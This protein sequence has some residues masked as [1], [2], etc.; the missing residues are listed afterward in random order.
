M[1]RNKF[2]DRSMAAFP[3]P[4]RPAQAVNRCGSLTIRLNMPVVRMEEDLGLIILTM[5]V[6]HDLS[7]IVRAIAPATS[8][9]R[10]QSSG[11]KRE[12]DPGSESTL[13]ACLTHASRTRKGLR[14]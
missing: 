11:F 1:R 9:V 4:K 5:L 8:V 2:E 14:P 10:W 3:D 7:S 13:A 12:F 6:L